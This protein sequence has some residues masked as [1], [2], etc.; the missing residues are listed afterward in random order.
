MTKKEKLLQVYLSKKEKTKRR[1]ALLS[2][3]K[4]YA[5][6]ERPV[7]KVKRDKYKAL[8]NI[9]R[10]R[11]MGSFFKEKEGC[12]VADCNVNGDALNPSINLT[13]ETDEAI[14][15]VIKNKQINELIENKQINE[16]IENK[17]IKS[18][19]IESNQISELIENKQIKDEQ[20]SL[21]ID[22]FTV[23]NK[24]Y[25][26]N[27]QLLTHTNGSPMGTST[28]DGTRCIGTEDRMEGSIKYVRHFVKRKPE[29][30]EER[31]KLPIYYEEMQI[32]DAIKTNDII[33]VSGETGSGKSTQIP[34]FIYENIS[35]ENMLIGMT[36]PRR[37]STIS[38]TKRINC[39]LGK[40][41]ASYKIRY[42]DTTTSQTRI[43]L[44]TEGVLLNELKHDFYLSKYSHIILDEI[45]EQSAVSDVIMVLLG[46]VIPLRR[47]QGVPLKLILMSATF[48]F[49]KLS[50]AF[51]SQVF[52]VEVQPQ[53]YKVSTFY[54]KETKEFYL[55]VI[56]EKIK[57]ILSL[58]THREETGFNYDVSHGKYKDSMF[59]LPRDVRNDSSS[60]ILVFLPGKREIYTL[61]EML[62]DLDVCPIP[63]HGMLPSS[64]QNEI[65]ENTAKRKVILATNIAET[66]ITVPDVVFVIDS[67]RRKYKVYDNACFYSYIIRF[68]SKA[69]AN[70]RSG[71]AG[72]VSNG[73]CFRL[74]TGEF[75]TQLQ[76]YE[77]PEI[78]NMSLDN[79]IL[80][81][82]SLGIEN[83]HNFPFI[84]KPDETRI[85]S[86]LRHLSDLGALENNN[87]TPIGNKMLRYPVD[88]RLSRL[89]AID[90]PYGNEVA[91]IVS[92]LS[93]DFDSNASTYTKSEILTK[94]ALII[95]YTNSA[96]RDTFASQNRLS[97]Y[98]TNEIL[99]LFRYLRKIKGCDSRFTLSPL[100]EDAILGLRRIVC[101]AYCDNLV[102]RVGND[103]VFEGKNVY[104][105]RAEDYGGGSRFVFTHM[106]A[107]R[108]KYYLKNVT[109]VDDLIDTFSGK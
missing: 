80:T 21:C 39:E 15:E 44:M 82:K 14:N 66:S 3:L 107:H 12:K 16:V 4:E 8:E 50:G 49:G 64:K 91:L 94:M 24:N 101:G 48:D 33:F 59:R 62:K 84:N 77:S 19:Q 46:K 27:T 69:G 22:N 102:T 98:Q 42:E 58:E 18:K 57:L 61:L 65:Y 73:V 45:H 72:R 89:L 5:Q 11:V 95:D 52:K 26:G 40:S 93:F 51:S 20:I 35:V 53:C 97:R 103:Y 43:K 99:K 56:L 109:C 85:M 41:A 23:H 2:E 55:E 29:I 78:T 81:L 106:E 71:R 1:D 70:Q 47:N 10:C 105:P 25:I 75:Y 37:I 31:Q 68:I 96:D 34:Q 83:I 54:E 104:I 76:D 17:Q 60:A 9:N 38:I 30:E 32:I 87:L 7:K 92:I 90:T 67:G 74:Y 108:D 86:G 63:L 100:T 36:Q 79:I 6:L 88:A 13:K 28:S